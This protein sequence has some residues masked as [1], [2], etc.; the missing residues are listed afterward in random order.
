[1]LKKISKSD[2][3]E[4]GRRKAIKDAGVKA[5]RDTDLITFEN[6]NEASSICNFRK[7]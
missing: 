7:G 5:I 4:P 1:M 6:I 2:I 3:H